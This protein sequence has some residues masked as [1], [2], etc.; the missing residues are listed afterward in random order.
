MK[1]LT[2]ALLFLLAL[3]AC[4]TDDTGGGD[5]FEPKTFVGA[6]RNTLSISGT[7]SQTLTDSVSI[8]TGSTSDL[9]LTSQLLGAVKATVI[10]KTSFSLD[11]Q[12]I[13]VTVDG[14]AVSVTIAGQGTVSDGVFNSTGTLS[15]SQA[16]LSFTWAGARL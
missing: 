16:S 4:G 1:P 8:A 5:D 9:I 14:Q 11:Q 7:G 10:G 13:F 2:I 12:Q 3:A 15:T 6:Y